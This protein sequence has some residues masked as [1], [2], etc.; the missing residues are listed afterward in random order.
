MLNN[1][2]PDLLSF[3][4]FS[5]SELD[6]SWGKGCTS[7]VCMLLTKHFVNQT[8]PRPNVFMRFDLCRFSC[9]RPCSSLIFQ[10]WKAPSIHNVGI[11]GSKVSKKGSIIIILFTRSNQKTCRV[12][13]INYV[14]RK[15]QK[16]SQKRTLVTTGLAHS[17]LRNCCSSH[18]CP[19]HVTEL[20]TP[21]RAVDHE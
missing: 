5:P 13:Q 7:K 16:E 19:L 9:Y 20:A 21:S 10:I 17:M 1:F 3:P 14:S 18:Q 8:P 11:L 6:K 15:S 12:Y 4:Y 2:S